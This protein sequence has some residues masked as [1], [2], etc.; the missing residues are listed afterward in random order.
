MGQ[1]LFIFSIEVF[2]HARSV[3]CEPE[4]FNSINSALEV[5]SKTQNDNFIEN[6]F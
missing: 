4:L 1:I 3:L 5:G 6:G 2:I